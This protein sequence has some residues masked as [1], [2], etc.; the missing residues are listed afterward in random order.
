MLSFILSMFL[1][2]LN[3]FS[4]WVFMPITLAIILFGMGWNLIGDGLA[5]A[6][7]PISTFYGRT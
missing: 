5:E 1:I 3:I 7:D 4:W 2:S 6:Y